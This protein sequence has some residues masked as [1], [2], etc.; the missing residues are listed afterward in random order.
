MPIE[1]ARKLLPSTTVIGMSISTVEEAIRVQ[2]GSPISICIP[3]DSVSGEPGRCRLCGDRRCISHDIEN[4][5]EGCAR[6]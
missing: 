1:V 4:A 3:V 5:Q 2:L 6:S